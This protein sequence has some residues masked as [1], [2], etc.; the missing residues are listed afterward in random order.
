MIYIDNICAYDIV[1]FQQTSN[2]VTNLAGGSSSIQGEFSCIQNVRQLNRASGF[3]KIT[4][5]VVVIK[6]WNRVKCSVV[7]ITS[8][9]H[10]SDTRSTSDWY[11]A[12]LNY[13]NW[14]FFCQKS[15]H[16]VHSGF[17]QI[18]Y[19]QDMLIPLPLKIQILTES[20]RKCAK[21]TA[22]N[23]YQDCK[24]FTYFGMFYEQYIYR[25]ILNLIENEDKLTNV[26][27][28]RA[29]PRDGCIYSHIFDAVN[30]PNTNDNDTEAVCTHPIPQ[31]FEAHNKF[32]ASTNAKDFHD[33]DKNRGFLSLQETNFKIS[34]PDRDFF[35]YSDI[36]QVMK[37]AN[38][39]KVTGLPNYKQARFP[40]KVA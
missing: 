18:V 21:M 8:P 37:I 38:I 27:V 30:P 31:I 29:R 32:L 5:V 2:Q 10:L 7:V 25:I 16:Y 4:F 34:G 20:E 35:D 14:Y 3:G 39:V 24:T 15:S 19:I 12:T 9:D 17:L 26:I 13:T 1:N 11:N 28:H 36:A 23:F 40:V 33:P 6:P 22:Q